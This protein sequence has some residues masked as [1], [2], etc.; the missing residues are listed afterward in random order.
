M[1][2]G[3]SFGYVEAAVLVYIRGLYEPIHQRLH[4]HAAAD[5]LFPLLTYAQ[6]EAEGPQVVHWLTMEMVRE[7]ATL[8]MLVGVG[9]AVGRTFRQWFAAFLIAFGLWDIF[10]YVFLRVLIGWPASLREWDLLFLLPVPWA[11]P[12]LAPV[13]VALAMVVVGVILLVGEATDRPVRLSL[14]NWVAILVGGAVINTAFCWDYRNLRA[15]GLPNPFNWPLF[16]LGEGM[17]LS[18]VLHALWRNRGNAEMPLAREPTE[19][20]L[21]ERASETR[22]R[23]R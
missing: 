8:L 15:G 17:V 11:A 6:L 18:G 4:P 13:L 16:A 20:I 10:Y 12:V 9:L 1:L 7:G 14:G 21:A 3:A 5:A 19:R 23:T 2:F 22:E